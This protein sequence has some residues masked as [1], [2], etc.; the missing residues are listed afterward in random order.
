[1][2]GVLTTSAQRRYPRSSVE[3]IRLTG[4]ESWFIAKQ[5][6]MVYQQMD[7]DVALGDECTCEAWWDSYSFFVRRSADCPIDQHRL[8]L[9]HI[10]AKKLRPE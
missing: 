9:L 4:P 8:E 2:E 6:R 5:L 7:G 10:G 3:I 1:V